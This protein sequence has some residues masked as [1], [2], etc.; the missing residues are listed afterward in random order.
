MYLAKYVDAIHLASQN[1]FL[2]HAI[3]INDYK[4]FDNIYIS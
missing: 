4:I 1:L 2:L 3:I